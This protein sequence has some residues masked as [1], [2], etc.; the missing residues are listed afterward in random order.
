MRRHPGPG[1]AHSDGTV[2]LLDEI[3]LCIGGHKWRQT[4]T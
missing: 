2:S 4:L 1:H 3:N